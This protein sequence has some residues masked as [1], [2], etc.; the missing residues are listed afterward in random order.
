MTGFC[1]KKTN[2]FPQSEDGRVVKAKVLR[3]FGAIRVGS[4]PTPRNT[5]KRNKQKN[6][7]KIFSK[8]VGYCG[9]WNGN[10]FKHL[11]AAEARWAHKRKQRNP[12]AVRS[13][14]TDAIFS[15]IV[16]LVR[17]SASQCRCRS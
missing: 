9:G 11:S 15:H 14:R 12:K 5:H 4:I 10:N 13:K 3:S 17:I 8:I 1:K 16:Q 6:K 2:N 7:K